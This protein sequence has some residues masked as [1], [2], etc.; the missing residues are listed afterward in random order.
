MVSDD[1]LFSLLFLNFSKSSKR[2]SNS[3]LSA[4]IS[5][6]RSVTF[7][8]FILYFVLN[9]SFSTCNS[10]LKLS[11]TLT[12][13]INSKSELF[14]VCI[15]EIS[16]FCTCSDNFNWFVV[17]I[18]ILSNRNNFMFWSATVECSVFASSWDVDKR[19]WQRG[20]KKR[21]SVCVCERQRDR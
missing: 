8:A 14:C 4:L 13:N 15:E 7:C 5:C 3:S 19:P 6:V 18:F 10:L 11:N 12:F 2:K 9:R 16:F 20:V 1:K 17:F 21:R